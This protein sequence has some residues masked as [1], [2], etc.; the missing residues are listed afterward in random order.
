MI[1]PP[2]SHYTLPSNSNFQQFLHQDAIQTFDY[3]SLLKIAP[4]ALSSVSKAYQDTIKKSKNPVSSITLQPYYGDPIRL[5]AWVFEYWVEIGRVVDIQRQWKVALSW[6]QKCSAWPSARELC[7]NLLLGVSSFSWSQSAA[8]IHDITSLFS[9]TPGEAYLSSYH[10]DHIVA[11]VGTQ[12]QAQLG[13]NQPNHH[14]FATVDLLGAIIR[15]YGA[16][17]VKKE[18][19]LWDSL[20]VIENKIIIGEVDSFGGIR[21][22][23]S[24]WVSIVINFQQ[25]QI[26]YGDSLGQQMPKHE[27]RAYERWVS[28]LINQSSKI[29]TLGTITLDQLPTRC[30]ND[31]TSCGLFA[32]NAIT[33]YYLGHPLLSPDPIALT[34]YRMEITLNIISKM[35]VCIFYTV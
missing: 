35:T 2:P 20:K 7:Y 11:W 1:S 26:L 8:Y 3:E 12:H 14:I 19:Y 6:V 9:D 34:C 10:I 18:G 24:H 4:P 29:S 30:Q 25:L 16:V 27:C 5:P 17:H 21:H 22:L 28:H 31:G 15:F 33:H 32:L 13:P 23:P